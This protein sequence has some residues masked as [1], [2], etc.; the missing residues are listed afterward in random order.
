MLWCSKG[1]GLGGAEAILEALAPELVAAG[2][3]VVVA[4]VGRA[5]DRSLALRKLGLEVL[6]LGGVPSLL[7]LRRAIAETRPAVVHVNNPSLILPA[8][9]ALIGGTAASLVYTEHSMWHSRRL[10]SQLIHPL[11]SVLPAATIA[12]SGAVLSSGHKYR[13]KCSVVIHGAALPDPKFQRS[14]AGDPVVVM[15]GSLRPEKDHVTGIRAF[16]LAAAELPFARLH[17][18]GD[19][20]MRSVIEEEVDACGLRDR[21]EMH[22][23]VNGGARL[24]DRETVLLVSSVSEGLP[25]A[26]GEALA[27][28]AQVVSTDVGGCREALTDNDGVLVGRLRPRGDAHALAEALVETALQIDTGLERRLELSRSRSPEHVAAHYDRVYRSTKS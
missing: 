2:W 24:L 22:G 14:L 25:I 12:V 5:S 19:G 17:I 1:L 8:F 7:G 27:A 4:N 11:A 18:I 10:P 6:E 9:V 13:R 16:Q 26:I 15:L 21:V 28:G 23:R 3:E 20:P